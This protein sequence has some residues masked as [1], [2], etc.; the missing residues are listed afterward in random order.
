[1]EDVLLNYLQSRKRT[2]AGTVETKPG[3]EPASW[4]NAGG[5]QPGSESDVFLKPALPYPLSGLFPLVDAHREYPVSCKELAAFLKNLCGQHPLED[6]LLQAMQARFPRVWM[7]RFLFILLEVQPSDSQTAAYVLQFRHLKRLLLRVERRTPL[8][9]VESGLA[10]EIIAA[11]SLSQFLDFD[12]YCRHAAE[13]FRALQAGRPPVSGDLGL[14]VYLI[15]C[16]CMAMGERKNWL[17]TD[18]GSGDPD[19]V[20]RLTPHLR[21]LEERMLKAREM[22][23][24]IGSYGPIQEA[25][26]GLEEAMG[27]FF[28]S[29]L[30]ECLGKS[31]SLAALKETVG[32]Q[33]AKR[34][35]TRDLIALS[36]LCRWLMEARGA[37]AG[38][39]EWVRM[40]LEAYDRGHFRL[41]VAG[42]LPAVEVLLS[43]ATV[44]REGT[45]VL[46]NFGENPY[47]PWI[48]RDGLTRPF[49]S[50]NPDR[51]A[52]DLRSTVMANIHRDNVI[53]KLLDNP[54][55][56]GAPGLVEAI[57]ECSR[58]PLV[59]SKIATRRE[60]HSGPVNG[61]VPVALLRSPVSISTVL[62]RSLI[63]PSLIAFPE[64]KSLY[65]GRSGLRR[66]VAE[67]LHDFLK[68]AYAI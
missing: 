44:E 26:M 63:H 39:L 16:E 8:N 49:H 21:L 25:P 4:T 64:I 6:A 3:L 47:S 34:V 62:I 29:H 55:V 22:A 5:R 7:E 41:D 43:E 68:Q 10:R 20:A 46:G 17:E 33:Q 61:R 53:L 58:S 45:L 13:A 65:R 67:E 57:V 31:P 12:P 27:P 66:D 48:A 9:A 23:E 28:F 36:T 14:L 56:Q 38:P 59:H 32:L 35:P 2:S 51:I 11:L 15:R 24:R 54:K 40:A 37:P 50:A 42:G 30:K 19:A 60:L 1:M 18:P 52:P